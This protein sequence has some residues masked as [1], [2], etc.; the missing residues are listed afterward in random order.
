MLLMVNLDHIMTD[1]TVVTKL[2]TNKKKGAAM[3]NDY[4]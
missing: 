4:Y 3:K 1:V 2:L